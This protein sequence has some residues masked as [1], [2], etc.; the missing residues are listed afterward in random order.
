WLEP[1]DEGA[2]SSE[3][4]GVTAQFELAAAAGVMN[5]RAHRG[6]L[7]FSFSCHEVVAAQLTVASVTEA[8]A[9][10]G[11]LEIGIG[12]FRNGE[13]AEAAWIR[14]GKRTSSRSFGVD[15]TIELDLTQGVT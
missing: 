13:Q 8:A 15:E 3:D 2:V 14:L 6:Y 7:A 9:A 1:Q 11:D 10:Y 5:G 4:E 12:S